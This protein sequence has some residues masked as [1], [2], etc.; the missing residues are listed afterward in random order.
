[1][2]LRTADRGDASLLGVRPGE[3]PRAAV[4]G[5][6]L[7]VVDGRATEVQVALPSEPAPA[8][9]TRLP[10][11]PLPPRC[12]VPA[13]DRAGL[14]L[15]RGG[16]DAGPVVVTADPV[17]LVAGPAGSGRTTALRTLAAQA[18]GSVWARTAD[19]QTVRAA[20]AAG[21]L[22]LVD[23]VVRPL[24]A[25]VEDALVSALQ[26][27]GPVR[28]VVAGEGQELTG[29]FRGV[30]ALARTTARTTVLLGRVDRVPAELVGRRPVPAPGRGPGA[31]F[32]VRDGVWTSVRVGTADCPTVAV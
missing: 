18:P 9:P 21:R 28:V 31:G 16:D 19:A 27:G 2:L 3:V 29:S 6:G 7:L 26:G 24:P 14:V 25:D 23:D 13:T 20:L 5:R 8:R 17:L 12:P 11:A 10:V 1:M 32:V 30:A 4:P 22:V 15:G